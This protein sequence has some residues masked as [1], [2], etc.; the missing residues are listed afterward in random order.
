VIENGDRG[1]VELI[2]E[3][4]WHILNGRSRGDWEGEYTYV[5]ARGSSIIDYAM[6]NDNIC[7]R[8]VEFR[9]D[10]RVDSNHMPL[11]LTLEEGTVIRLEENDAEEDR[12]EENSVIKEEEIIV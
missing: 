4:D 1:F 6:V 12:N 11:N 10:V 5:G 2:T 9:I 7:D 8:I 3:Y